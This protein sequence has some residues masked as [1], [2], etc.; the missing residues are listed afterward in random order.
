MQSCR[1]RI[2]PGGHGLIELNDYPRVEKLTRS[3]E[4]LQGVPLHKLHS[5]SKLGESGESWKVL[6]V[7][8]VQ[9]LATT[10]GIAWNRAT[11][12]GRPLNKGARGKVLRT[13]KG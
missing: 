1:I 3:H 4:G 11:V 2:S 12:E 5:V 13:T 9:I 10:V 8:V 7:L 6:K